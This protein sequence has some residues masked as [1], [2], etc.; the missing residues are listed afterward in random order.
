MI[1]IRTLICLTGW[2]ALLVTVSGATEIDFQVKDSDRVYW[3]F[4]PLQR[5]PG[6]KADG[7]NRIDHFIA[8]KLAAKGLTMNPPAGKR[9]FIRRA[10]FDLTGLPPT[11]EEVAAFEQD[12]HPDSYAQLIDR[13]LALPAY[14]ERWGRHWL[15]IARFAQS[16]G[17][18]FDQEKK[19]AWR[20]RDYVIKA[21]NEDKPY[22]RFVMEQLAGDEMPDATAD[23]VVATGF[24]RLGLWDANVADKIRAEYDGLDDILTT[25]TG[26]FLGL[27]IG[28]ARCHDHKLDP[29]SQK[30]YYS[31]LAFFR[32]VRYFDSVDPNEKAAGFAPLAPPPHVSKSD[33]AKEWALAVREAGTD[34]SRTC[35][36]IRG[37][38][39]SE[40]PEVAPALP[41]VLSTETPVI[42]PVPGGA[43]SGRRLALA[44]WIASPKNPLTARVMVN[45]VWKHHFEKGIVRTTSDF[46]R[47]GAPPTH[48]ELLD[49][50]AAAFIDSGWSVKQLHRLIMLSQT[51]RQ[52]SVADRPE[53]QAADPGN[54]WLWRQELR[55][56]EAEAIRDSVLHVSGTLN[57]AMGGR[58]FFP[59]LSGEVL[60]GQSRPGLDW[61]AS[62]EEEQNRRSVYAVVRRSMAV[63]L[64]QSLDYSNTTSPLTERATTTVAPQALILLNNAFMHKKAAALADRLVREAGDKPEAQIKRAWQLALNRDPSPQELKT[65]EQLLDRQTKAFTALKSRMTFKPDVSEALATEYSKVL[66]PARFM[67]GP[68]AGW[69]YH[70]GHWGGDYNGTQAVDRERG[71]FALWEGADLK[72]GAIEAV[73]SLPGETELG[74]LL[75][76][77]S[78]AKDES[79]GYEIQINRLREQISLRRHADGPETL[80]VAEVKIPAGEVI[81]LRVEFSGGTI[82]V[83]L[84]GGA[85]PVLE[86]TDAKPLE[87]GTMESGT[88]VGVR[89][90]GGSL[91]VESLT[92]HPPDNASPIT[93]PA[94]NPEPARSALQSLCLLIFNLNEFVYIQ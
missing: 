59:H 81:P 87:S 47:G 48:P 38:P 1:L 35:I 51:Y 9:E 83:F 62:S 37:N 5:L 80:S 23:S 31:M 43:S 57:P 33:P 73:V 20:Y 58:G 78:A 85:T 25:T 91:R 82:R 90:W 32:G 84:R 28:C 6:E 15:D 24:Q 66:P 27:T 77:A 17:Y 53:A 45:R 70:R 68:S 52:S 8:A 76:R 54:D 36:H 14:G 18:E 29:I 65:G 49:M 94:G 26:A 39:R 40:G 3:A 88:K 69:S 61:D 64:L 74:S 79:R 10:T 16:H 55:R 56:L 89:V 92:L 41:A 42:T 19:L 60:A 75:F 12:T 30:D 21:F 63:P 34:I 72:D 44:S 2:I 46:G 93:V 67:I 22:D 86:A 11:P 71:P 50:M 7:T 13:L 4:Q